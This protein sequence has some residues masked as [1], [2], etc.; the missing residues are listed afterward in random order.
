MSFA[1]LNPTGKQG[2]RGEHVGHHVDP[3]LTVP[4][5]Q[6]TLGAGSRG[7]AGVCEPDVDRAQR[8][9]D[10]PDQ[11]QRGRLVADVQ[12]ARDDRVAQ[13][14]AQALNAPGV[15]VGGHHGA[16]AAREQASHE[17]AADA[18]GRAGHDRDPSLGVHRADTIFGSRDSR[19]R[20]AACTVAAI[21]A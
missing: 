19:L 18:A 16:G 2:P 15:E 13:L 8:G 3:P 20:A 7:Q 21:S 17:R 5:L 10:V 12:L 11:R 4:V 6:R 14:P 9:L 1:A